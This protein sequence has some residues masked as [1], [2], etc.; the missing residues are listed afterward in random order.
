MGELED[1]LAKTDPLERADALVAYVNEK[2]RTVGWDSLTGIERTIFIVDVYRFK[3]IQSGLSSTVVWD[4]PDFRDRAISALERIGATTTSSILRRAAAL[5]D[6]VPAERMATLHTIGD[7]TGALGPVYDE[8]E[9][10][11]D[12]ADPWNEISGCLTD[13]IGTC[14]SELRAD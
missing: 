6:S 8:L 13:W 14:R 12:R 1:A 5:I 7:V 3:L 4:P 2:N 11:L 10:D 9:S